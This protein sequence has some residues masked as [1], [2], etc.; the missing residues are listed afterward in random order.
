MDRMDL[1]ILTALERDGRQSFNALAETVGLSKTPCWSR[2]Q[3]LEKSGAIRSYH[4][5]V[6]PAALG[7]SVHA[8]VQVMIDP[9]RR[10]DFETAVLDHPSVI[11]CSTT[12]GE[13]DYLLKVVCKDVDALDDLLRHGLSLLPGLQRSNTM[14]CL[15]IIKRRGLL[16]EAAL[17]PPQVPKR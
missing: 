5:D 1:S 6:D 3:N 14:V 8:Y 17:R 12:A 7:L 16:A 4:A 2:V 11:E 15:K 9:A 10:A 13:A